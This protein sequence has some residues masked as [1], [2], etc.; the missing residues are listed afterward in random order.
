MPEEERNRVSYDFDK[1]VPEDEAEDEN[2]SNCIPLIP[3]S[4]TWKPRVRE[5]ISAISRR[6]PLGR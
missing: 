2:A 6:R 1:A 5:L 4:T 3:Q